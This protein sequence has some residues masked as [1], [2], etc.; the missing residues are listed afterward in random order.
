MKDKINKLIK[1]LK[2]ENVKFQKALDKGLSKYNSSRARQTIHMNT[3][4]I[5]RLEA[6][7]S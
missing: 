6:T 5:G 4:F 7:L 1:K 3:E 2:L